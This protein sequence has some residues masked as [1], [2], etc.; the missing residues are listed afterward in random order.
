MKKKLLSGVLALVLALAM[1]T[2]CGSSASETTTT[3]VETTAAETT[4]EETT[5]E[6]TTVEETTAEESAYPITVTDMA[7]REVTIEAPAERIV[8]LHPTTGYL[9]WRLGGKDKMVSIDMVFQMAYCETEAEVKYFSDEDLEFLNSLEVTGTFFKNL[10]N[11]QIMALEPDIIFT[12]ASDSNADSLSETFGCPVICFTKDPMT[13]VPEA[14]RLAGQVIG[15]PDDA[16]SMATFWEDLLDEITD[17]SSK[18]ADDEKLKVFYTGKNGNIEVTPTKGTVFEECM[19][20][21]GG[22]SV[23]DSM[24]TEGNEEA[25]FDIE[26]VIAWDPDYIIAASTEAKEAILA[27]SN[28]ANVRAVQE[29]N[30]IVPRAYAGLD[31]YQSILGCYWLQG[32]LYHADDTAWWDKFNE[33]VFDYYELFYNRT[34]DSEELNLEA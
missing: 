34:L 9:A 11:E 14:F 20:N 8:E 5:T 18:L 16:E 13:E 29:G 24:D 6:E 3:Q 10:N 33:V 17:E 19:T 32:E 4:Q 30:I 2:S 21:A 22:N 23:T 31:G 25:E 26:Q 28:W 1:L 12:M 15:N 7:G 27:D